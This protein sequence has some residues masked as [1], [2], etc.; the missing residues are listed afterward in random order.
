MIPLPRSS[1]YDRT[2]P[3]VLRLSDEQ[4]RERRETIQDELSGD[5]YP[6]SSLSGIQWTYRVG[7][8]G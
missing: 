7:K 4:V 1:F 3:P 5:G 8:M 2:Q 6:W